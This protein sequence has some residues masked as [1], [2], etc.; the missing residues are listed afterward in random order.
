MKECGPL[1]SIRIGAGPSSDMIG[2]LVRRWL[3]ED[4]GPTETRLC[5]HRVRHW[6]G[7]P[8]S[9]E[10]PGIARTQEKPEEARKEAPLEHLERELGPATPR[11]GLL[12]SKT[13]RQ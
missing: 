3:W 12:T 1:Y 7:P 9:Q 10:T 11:F 2:A 4:R 5:D 8:T 13:V 6:S